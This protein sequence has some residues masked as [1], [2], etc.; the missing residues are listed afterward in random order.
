M[1]FTGDHRY[2]DG[3]KCKILNE[4]FNKVWENPWD[5]SNNNKKIE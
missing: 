5:Y 2:I 3:A 1:T 4:T